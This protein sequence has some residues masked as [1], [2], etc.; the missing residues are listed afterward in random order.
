MLSAHFSKLGFSLQEPIADDSALLV[1]SLH[2]K[3]KDHPMSRACCR[4]PAFFLPHPHTFADR[5]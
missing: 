2:W 4:F 5:R 1:Q 3:R